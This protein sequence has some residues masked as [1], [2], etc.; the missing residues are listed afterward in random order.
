MIKLFLSLFLATLLSFSCTDS[1]TN[2][3]TD[4]TV[5][6]TTKNEETAPVAVTVA[7]PAPMEETP[8]IAEVPEE[9][10]TAEPVVTK[11]KEEPIKDQARPRE[12]TTTSSTPPTKNVPVPK[13]NPPVSNTSNNTIEAGKTI[14][15]K[16]AI[17]TFSHDKLDALL[18][19]HVSSSGQVDYKTFKKDKPVLEDYINLLELNAPEDD[20]S[21]NKE[22]AYWI[23]LY[24]AFTINTILENYPVKSITDIEGGK[25]WDRKTISIGGERLTLN[26]IEKK[27]LL[28][29]FKDSRV[30]FAVNCA[31]ASCP[32]L[33]NKAWTEDNVQ[34]YL[35]KQTKAFINNSKENQL[36]AESIQVSQIFNWYADDFGGKDKI[37]AY[38]QKYA[39]TDISE[40]AKVTFNEYDWGLND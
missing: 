27:K 30:H 26:D 32:P 20:W 39:D 40:K 3:T 2:D 5:D 31:A 16:P 33:L 12:T 6:N 28:K 4:T 24:N 13:N 15:T 36:A 19:K 22:M 29:R 9:T 38:F 11:P 34:R 7:D 18:R 1:P 21:K 17:P 37:V 10:T 25:V 14:G 23:N 35:Q 8:A